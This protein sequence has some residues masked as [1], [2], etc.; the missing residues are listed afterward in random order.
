MKR[1]SILLML[2]VLGIAESHA[3]DW[4]NDLPTIEA[5]IDLHKMIKGAEDG[6]R[7]RVA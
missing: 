7:D 3:I 5:L 1:I 6:A 4:P 2:A